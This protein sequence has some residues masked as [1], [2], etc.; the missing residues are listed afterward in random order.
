MIKTH[1]NSRNEIGL[2]GRLTVVRLSFGGKTVAVIIPIV[3]SPATIF[4]ASG[5]E[6]DEAGASGIKMLESTEIC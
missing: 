5:V 6:V 3:V 2:N 4:V 1:K